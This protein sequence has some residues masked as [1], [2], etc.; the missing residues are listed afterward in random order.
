MSVISGETSEDWPPNLGGR[1]TFFVQNTS[2][3]PDAIKTILVN[4]TSAD[5]YESFQ[6]MRV[7][8]PALEA[9][10]AGAIAAVVV[11]FSGPPVAAG[12]AITL[13]VQ[14]SSGAMATRRFKCAPPV[15]AVANLL[16]EP[17]DRALLAYLRNDSDTATNI[18]GIS[19]NEEDFVPGSPR[20]SAYGQSYVIPPRGLCI[21]RIE[22]EQLIAPLTPLHFRVQH[23]GAGGSSGAFLRHL[24]AAFPLATWSSDLPNDPDGMTVARLL[25]ID[26]FTGTRNWNAIYAARDRFHLETL[27]PLAVSTE[28]DIA[29]DSQAEGDWAWLVS[30]EP[31]LNST[32]ASELLARNQPVWAN[33]PFHPTFV[34]LATS[35]AFNEYAATTDII[36][37]DHYAMYSAPNVV[38]FTWIFREARMEEALQWTDLLKA[39][40][41]P[42]RMWSWVQLAARGTW[43][44]QPEPWGVAYQFWAHVMSG[45]KGLLWFRY[46]PG[47][48]NRSDTEALI[49]ESES[50]ARMLSLVRGAA[51]Y[52]EPIPWASLDQPYHARAL[53][54]PQSM[55]AVVLND[56]HTQT[57]LPPVY[58]TGTAAGNLDLQLPAWLSAPEVYQVTPEGLVPIP[59]SKAGAQLR[60]PFAF[61]TGAAVYLV[62][63]PEH[64]PPGAPAGLNFAH[65]FDD[66]RVALSWQEPWDN[67]GI[68]GY[69][70]YQNGELIAEPGTP[71]LVLASPPALQDRFEV[72]AYDPFGNESPASIPVAYLAYEFDETGYTQTWRP[73]NVLSNTAPA[74][75]AENGALVCTTNEGNTAVLYSAPVRVD[76]SSIGSVSLRIA[77][78]NDSNPTRARFYW[79]TEE[80]PS[81]SNA[82]SVTF[83]LKAPGSSFKT[84][85][86]DLLPDAGWSGII[87]RF[88][89][90]PSVEAA[91]AT[92]RIDNLTLGPAESEG[93]GQTE[94]GTEG[95]GSRDG[96][97]F[98]DGEGTYEGGEEGATEGTSEGEVPF[99]HSADQSENGAI[100]LQELLRVIQFYNAGRFGCDT[101]SEDGY[102]PGRDG[103]A[104][105]PHDSDFAPQ[106]WRIQLGELLRLI[107]L[108]T[109]GGYRVCGSTEDGFC[110]T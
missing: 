106:D 3:E 68:A 6:W 67:T 80:A 76:A 8:P 90:T 20:L 102:A 89:F 33:D 88:R 51:F 32:S 66:G 29:S 27:R 78:D 30:D 61:Q 63:S 48:E 39:N 25:G 96:A 93:E 99:F 73:S 60:I 34:T 72:T 110:P 7:W 62:G 16:P 56:A 1:L 36:S 107:Q 84:Y 95:E 87:T 74:L 98:P 75:K 4:E 53:A 109:L 83:R 24:P 41:E 100:E 65:H 42:Q 58:N 69:R 49:A 17:D 55:L 31:D 10:G 77:H 105:D 2:G 52:G 81:F 44:V 94:G 22:M 54:G 91:G 79:T 23:D 47:Y 12:E 18:T 101:D 59:S 92:F 64:L 85:T 5:N 19:L 86:A 97:P 104:C 82:R 28:A 35:A 45:A 50:L 14:M 37:M 46:A 40:S 13:G 57:G 43:N 11:C 71:A 26:T 9:E 21:V 38:P 70:V 108:Y 103:G 15:V